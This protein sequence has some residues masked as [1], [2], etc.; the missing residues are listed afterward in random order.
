MFIVVLTA[1]VNGRRDI[2]RA[3]EKV[4]LC[5]CTILAENDRRSARKIPPSKKQALNV[6][7]TSDLRDYYGLNVA[8]KNHYN[9]FILSV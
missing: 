1:E 2:F 7:I 4:E 9:K 5:Y 6:D 8:D 3:T